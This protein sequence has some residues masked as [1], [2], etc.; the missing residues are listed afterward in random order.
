MSASLSISRATAKKRE[1]T[2]RALARRMAY[3]VQ[4]YKKSVTLE[5]MNPYERRIIHSEVQNIPGVTTIS[6]GNDTDRKI[7]IYPRRSECP[8]IVPETAAA[9]ITEVAE[10]IAAITTATAEKPLRL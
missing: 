7:I 4:K 9:I 1:Q 3:R 6:V 5:P 8:V 10:A 2:L